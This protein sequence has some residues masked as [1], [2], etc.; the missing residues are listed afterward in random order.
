MEKP[1]EGNLRKKDPR[2]ILGPIACIYRSHLA[3]MVKELE[4]YR[5]G[6]GQFEFLMSLY[7][8]DGVSQ[9][10]LAKELKVSKATSARAIQ[11]L[12]KEGYVYRERDENDLRAY[13]VYLTEKGKEM[14]YIIFKKL[15]AFTDILFSD[16]TFEEKEIFRM[17]IHKAVT[18][19]FEPGFEPPSGRS[20]D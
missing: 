12:E 9:E 14:R 7:Y 8:K 1:R 11:N 13:R 15:T 2:E 16:F 4:A 19:L 18:K 5:V 6:S 3:Y 20:D 17:L 10:T